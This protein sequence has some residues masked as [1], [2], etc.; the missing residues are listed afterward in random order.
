MMRPIRKV[1]F[2]AEQAGGNQTEYWEGQWADDLQAFDGQV[3]RLLARHLPSGGRVLEAGCGQGQVVAGL[4]SLGHTVIGIDLAR[5][6]LAD[7]HRRHPTLPLGVGDVGRM[8]FPDA[9]FKAVVSLGVIEHFEAGPLPVLQEHRRVLDNQGVLFLTVP[10][11]GWYRTWTDF[12]N[13]QFG[14]ATSYEQ[15][16]RTVAVRSETRVEEMSG[17]TFH[18][19]EFPR[20]RLVDLLG[21]AGFEVELWQPFDVA[22]ALGESPVLAWL[23]SKRASGSGD[24]ISDKTTESTGKP[25]ASPTSLGPLGGVRRVVKKSANYLRTPII[26][27]THGDVPQRAM[28]YVATR[29]LSHMQL[30][31]ARPTT[32]RP[33]MSEH[34][35]IC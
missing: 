15:R 16:G 19:Y 31:V 34:S 2:E 14:R 32:P 35:S 28:A 30:L 10:A 11:R 26:E 3:R 7:C 13:L 23:A 6:A 12:R 24:G 29:A 9:T 8:P 4:A 25:T 20:G 5:R 33:R 1:F 17:R 21:A 22:S 18:Q 27:E